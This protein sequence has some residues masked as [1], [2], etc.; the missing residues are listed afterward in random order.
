M[1][2]DLNYRKKLWTKEQAGEVMAK[3]MPYVDVCIANE[4]DAADVFGIRAEGTDINT[5]KISREGYIGVARELSE[6]FGCSYVAITLRGS[7]SATDNRWAG[8]LY[9][10]GKAC[11]SHYGNKIRS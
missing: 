9:Q 7:I 4:E 2:C 11:F 5:G 10:D 1:S 3:L 6:R 8:M